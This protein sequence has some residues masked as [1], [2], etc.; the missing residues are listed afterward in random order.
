MIGSSALVVDASVAVS[1]VRKEP[2]AEE[3]A[4]VIARWTSSGSRLVVPGQFWLEVTNTLIKRQKWAGSRV[5]Q[6]IRELD[7]MQLE[8][9]EL[10][11]GLVVLTIDLAERHG[12]STYDAGYLA[13]AVSMDASIAT[14]DAALS[15]GSRHSRCSDRPRALFR[16]AGRLRAHRDVAELQGRLGI[17]REASRRRLQDPDSRAG[18]PS[19]PRWPTASAPGSSSIASPMTGGSR[20]CSRTRAGRSSRNATS[21]TGRS[22]RASRTA[23]PSRSTWS[24]GASSPRRPARPIDPTVP[25]IALG[26]IVQKGGKIVHAWAVEGDLDAAAAMSNTFEME[27]PPRSGRR[28]VFPEIDRV[29]WFEPD[30]A[31]QRVKA[32]QIPFIDRL[33]AALAGNAARRLG[34]RR[35]RDRHADER[36][37]R[38]RGDERAAIRG[39]H[40]EEQQVR[41]RRGRRLDGQ[42]RVE[43]LARGESDREVRADRLGRGI[44][45]ERGAVRERDPAAGQ[46]GDL[47]RDVARQVRGRLDRR[48]APRR[49]AEVPDPD[50][51]RRRR[52]RPRCRR[53]AAAWTSPSYWPVTRMMRDGISAWV[54]A[55]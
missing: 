15:G 46:L 45:R 6:A 27:W 54:S 47:G 48:R 52:R 33:E 14:F 16:D 37:V 36:R 18:L 26:S 31:R 20:C 4:L 40:V 2:E 53:S 28:E 24:P 35:R 44:G 10:D 12:L 39:D 41:A 43:R 5:L 23:R 34:L 30:E 29:G 55:S 49:D 11:R 32:S 8:T 17:P 25:T 13:L 42:C 21:A 50:T 3:A 51:E 7:D 19:D 9:I 1:I 38:A 22:R